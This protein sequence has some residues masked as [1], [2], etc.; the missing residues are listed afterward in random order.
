MPSNKSIVYSIRIPIESRAYRWLV[1]IEERGDNVSQA[2]RELI[3]QH[4]ETY[5][6]DG[7]AR[8]LA[9]ERSS[10]RLYSLEYE[11]L[12]EEVVENFR[13]W[14]RKKDDESKLPVGRPPKRGGSMNWYKKG[15]D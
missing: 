4:L 1:V 10:K 2:L 15:R 13:T 5:G 9:L 11:Y 12:T 3:N 6:E 8:L 7:Y 14:Y